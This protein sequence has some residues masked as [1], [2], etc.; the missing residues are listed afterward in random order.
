MK[1]VHLYPDLCSLYGDWANVAVVQRHLT[2]LGLEVQ[3]ERCASCRQSDFSGADFVFMGASTEKS[4]KAVLEDFRCC[5]DALR[6]AAEDGVP[7]LF[8]GC[9]FELLGEDVTDASGSVHSCLGLSPFHSVEGTKRIVGDVYGATGLYDA[10]VVG[11]MN[12]CSRITGVETPLLTGLSLGFGNSD[13]LGPEGLLLRH[14]A[15][16]HLTGPVL[17]KN[18]RLLRWFLETICQRAGAELPDEWPIYPYEEQGYDIT[19]RELRKRFEK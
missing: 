13:D 6:R 17:V 8:T 16:T 9:S 7:M 5:G 12:K 4:Q 11:F 3:V 15:G 1:L 18:P 14:V 10:P 19:V 2:D